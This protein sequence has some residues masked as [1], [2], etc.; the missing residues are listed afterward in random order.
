MC[1]SKTY[2]H[3]ETFLIVS[4]AFPDFLSSHK[5]L[6]ILLLGRHSGLY[7]WC[8]G[9]NPPS[10]QRRHSA[11]R[12]TRTSHRHLTGAYLPFHLAGQPFHRSPPNSS[13]RYHVH[14]RTNAKRD[15]SFLRRTQ[16]SHPTPST[17]AATSAW[18]AE[19]PHAHKERDSR[20]PAHQ[21]KLRYATSLEIRILIPQPTVLEYRF[22]R[23]L[24]SIM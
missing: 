21:P 16:D 3:L 13:T 2:R 10:V 11:K 17:S 4:S 12:A 20:P 6:I 7:G 24:C 14:H 23:K 1:F 22:K 9:H 15:V 19:F 18:W 8:A 5:T